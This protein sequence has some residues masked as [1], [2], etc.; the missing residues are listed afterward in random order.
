[1]GPK[2]H[3]QDVIFKL[4]EFW[5]EQGCTVLQPHNLQIREGLLNPSSALGILG[6]E[7][8][9]TVSVEKGVRPQDGRFG[10]H[11]FRLQL[12]HQLQVILK[13]EP[14]NPQELYLQSLEAIGLFANENDIRFVADSWTSPTIGVWGRGWEIWLNGLEVTQ[15]TYLQQAGGTQL[16]PV[17]LQI[18][19][20]LERLVL[21]LQN[22]KTLWEIKYSEDATYADLFHSQEVEQCKYL[23]DVA[24]AAHLKTLYQLYLRESN[25]CLTN[26]LL[27]PAYDY[28]L[29]L[30][31]VFNVLDAR[32]IVGIAERIQFSK[33][34]RRQY[35]Q[36][37]AKYLSQR[38]EQGFPLI[39]H[40][41]SSQVPSF[42]PPTQTV[43]RDSKQSFLLEIGT[44]EF[45]VKA[46]ESTIR[47]LRTKVPLFLD[48]LGFEYGRVEIEGT[49]R[50]ISINVH[51]LTGEQIHVAEAPERTV[52]ILADQLPHLIADIHF[53]RSMRWN[54]SN[55]FFAR[56]IRWIV[57]LFGQDL[58][59]FSY[60]G[61]HS[62][63]TSRGLRS[64]FS[65]DIR[66]GDAY[67]YAGVLRKN[68]ITHVTQKRIDKIKKVSSKLAAEKKGI[69][70]NDKE[71]IKAVSNLVEKPTPLRG[72]FDSDFLSL[73]TEILVAVM[74]NRQRYFPVFGEDG[75]L[76]PYFLAVRNG[77]EKH[78]DIVIEGNEKVLNGR[79]AD[80]QFFYKKDSQLMLEAFVPK[81][82]AVVFHPRLGSMAE[83]TGRV[84]KLT[85]QI[86]A[87]LEL[88]PEELDT[89]TRAA[90][91]SKADLATQIVQE[92]NSLQGVMGGYYAANSG[93]S[94]EVA[95]AISEQYSRLS[96]T[97]P[98]LVLSISDMIDSLIGL[99]AAGEV[100]DEMKDPYQLQR[101]ALNLLQKLV[102]C[103]SAIDLREWIAIAANNQPLP[104]DEQL[105]HQ[106][107][108]FIQKNM[109]NML[110][111]MGFSNS[112]IR[113]TIE[114][115][116][117]YNPQLIFQQIK[118]ESE[119]VPSDFQ[120]S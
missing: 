68:G 103:D 11:P 119:E 47:Q 4:I 108:A 38:E 51:F 21:A 114:E 49:P 66:I 50:R 7:P 20:G 69:I 88:S 80:A 116:G 74:K 62:G 91:L 56:P 52:S 48:K 85:A 84:Q 53:N 96:S 86:G 106:L 95:T 93:E 61:V 2:L 118:K 12:H 64:D 55:I 63:R 30:A 39:D 87:R 44:E 90:Y 75:E 33:Q 26:G 60:A 6:P 98:S 120:F 102:R 101:M 115:F 73:P 17:P 25:H 13:P 107:L 5:K 40:D 32:G 19:Y 89:V 117:N 9:R 24:D 109:E 104:C 42:L 70:Y 67:T 78:L 79:F 45:P 8:L 1:M 81:L 65:P 29:K 35:Q 59:P 100:P 71:L 34:M 27:Y 57:A 76:L 72:Q 94:K 10:S 99:F 82:T 28:C 37:A 111:E 113:L 54:S 23:F 3:F 110:L 22:V 14:G 105:Q 16:D 36:I 83:K 41:T 77:D 18:T 46:L 112:E 43:D 31:H 58:I 92:M 97:K 15:F